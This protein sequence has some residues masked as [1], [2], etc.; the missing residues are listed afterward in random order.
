MP[1]RI[2]SINFEYRDYDNGFFVVFDIPY[3][4]E[5]YE[6]VC[7]MPNSA[8]IKLIRHLR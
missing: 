3:S 1:K 4:E 2:F 7:L 8:N 6:A 5:N